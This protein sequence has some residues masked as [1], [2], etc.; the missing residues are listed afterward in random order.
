MNRKTV[1]AKEFGRSL[2]IESAGVEKFLGGW[3][4]PKFL[5]SLFGGANFLG[6]QITLEPSIVSLKRAGVPKVSRNQIEL[7]LDSSE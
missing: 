7:S 3:L 5:F 4:E 1:L 6:N 2:F